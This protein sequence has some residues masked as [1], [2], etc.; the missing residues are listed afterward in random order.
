M[1]NKRFGVTQFDAQGNVYIGEVDAQG[2]AI[3]IYAPALRKPPSPYTCCGL[4]VLTGFV[5]MQLLDYVDK[6]AFMEALR[7]HGTVSGRQYLSF[8]VNHSNR[9]TSEF[10]ALV[11]GG[12]KKSAE[13]PNLQPGH[14]GYNL[15][16]YLWNPADAVGIFY[17]RNGRAY[18]EDPRIKKASV[19]PAVAVPTQGPPKAAPRPRS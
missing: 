3:N 12:A 16:M 1:A 18:T 15:E 8:V 10:L 7:L 19:E 11:E 13:F 4:S 5:G 9:Q 14:E 17:D 6:A 2:R